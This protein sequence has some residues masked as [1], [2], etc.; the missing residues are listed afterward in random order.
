M[1][2]FQKFKKQLLKD[3][4]IRKAYADL[5]PEFALIEMIIEKRL[6]SGLTQKQ[7]AKKVGT[8]QPAIARLESG[9]SNPSIQFLEKVARALGARLRVSIR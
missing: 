9:Y 3:Q 8:K 1:K 6:K 2:S 4:R 5:G 7:L